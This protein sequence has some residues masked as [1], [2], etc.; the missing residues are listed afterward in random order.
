MLTYEWQDEKGNIVE[1][2]QPDVPPDNKRQWKRVFSFGLTSI[3]GA[4]GSPG[5]P[6]VSRSKTSP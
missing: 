4:G 3:N 2:N 6:P 5:R 1:T